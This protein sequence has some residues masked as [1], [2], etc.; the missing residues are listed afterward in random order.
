MKYRL[1]IMVGIICSVVLVVLAAGCAGAADTPTTPSIPM[2]S[3][4]NTEHGFS[5]EYPEGWTE[6]ERGMGKMFAFEFKDTEGMLTG[7]VSVEYR[8]EELVLA[9]LVLETKEYME[10][11]AQFELF[12]EGYVTIGEGISGY[13]IVGKGDLGTGQ[14]ENFRYVILM[15]EKQGFWV[16]VRG[17]P[18]TFDR[19]EQLIDTIVDSFKLLST[20]TYVPP[21]PGAEGIYTNT[22][23]GFSITYPEGWL[24]LPPSGRPGEVVSRTSAD[25]LPNVSVS[26]MTVGEGTILAEYGQQMSQD[27]SQHWGDY[28]LVSQGEITLDDGTPAYEIVF[29]GSMMDYNLKGKYVIVI[30]NTQV[31]FITG[32]SSPARFEQDEAI[33]DEVINT[34]HLE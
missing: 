20:Y 16:G 1:R 17:E 9:D 3:Y 31:F 28:E 10:A 34:F 22:E 12:S 6:N 32:F 8:T 18:T 27:L 13:E 29:S 23:H 30:Q 24:D 11:S 26:V 33:I 5:I 19:Q 2:V 25:G 7:E 15:R 21:T 14:V 4:E